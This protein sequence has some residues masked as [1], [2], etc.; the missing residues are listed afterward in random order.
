M[1]A[2]VLIARGDLAGARTLT[3]EMVRAGKDAAD[4]QLTSWGFQNLGRALVAL[5][6]LPEAEAVLRE[7]RALAESI[8]AWD[9]LLHL[10]AMLVRCLVL[11][12]EI[13]EC[14][15]LLD[16]AHRIIQRE[17]MDQAFDSVEVL[18]ADAAY[19]VAV[20]EQEPGASGAAALREARRACDKAARCA[21]KMPMWLPTV[22]RLQ[23]TAD[24]L[25]G[26]PAA[27]RRRWKESLKVAELSVFPIERALTLLEKG[28]R[29]GDTELVAQATALFRQT[30]ANTY[31]A[32]AKPDASV[33]ALEVPLA[34]TQ[35][36]A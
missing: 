5:G 25:G 2:W 33:P 30:G 36:A 19:R 13:Q 17:K 34:A 18:V 6:P 27:A 23:G 4:P 20:A 8:Q 14:E 7:G 28:Q 26:H 24:W 32:M 35:R 21:R 31:L 15:G 9:N 12:G 16:E 1:L 22:L 29:T 3:S 10:Q 11:K